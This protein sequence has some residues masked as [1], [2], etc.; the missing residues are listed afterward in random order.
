M[1]NFRIDNINPEIEQIHYRQS[2]VWADGTYD[3][4]RTCSEC[5]LDTCPY[6]VHKD[7]YKEITISKAFDRRMAQTDD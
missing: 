1:D 2:V 3:A 5:G 4:K 6:P 7:Y